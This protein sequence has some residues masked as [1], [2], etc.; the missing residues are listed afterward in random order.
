MRRVLGERKKIVVTSHNNPDGDAMGSML[1]MY[2]YLRK[3]GHQVWAVLPNQYPVFY[4]WMPG[5]KEVLVYEKAA[6]EIQKILAEA[7]L[8]FCLDY[9]AIDRFGAASEILAK[10]PARRIMID[11]HVEPREEDF[12]HAISV[13]NTSSTGE[14]VYDFIKMMKD[15]SLLDKSIADCLYTSI[16]TDTGSFSYSANN[17]STYH[18]TAELIALGVDASQIH[19]LIYDTFSE[20]RLRLLGH[21]ISNK[22]IVWDD[23]HAALIC[24]SR[25]DL[26]KYNYKVGDTEG[27]VNYPL[28]MEKVNL[29]VLLTEKENMIRLSFRS[30]GDFSVNELARKHFRG[31]GHPNAAGGKLYIPLEKAIESIKEVLSQYRKE[32]DFKLN[33]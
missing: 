10:S 29:S 16:V 19:R 18:V 26:K 2:H 30:K 1:A 21:G 27:L 12:D 31:G 32:L 11:H 13:I 28:M 4:D 25:E 6:K 9:N 8:V 33:Y 23:L 22:M 15:E 7:E 20:N 5:A 24:L 14:L 3:K 17:V